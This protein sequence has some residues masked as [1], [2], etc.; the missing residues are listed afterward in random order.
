MQLVLFTSCTIDV[1]ASVLSV[2]LTS[3]PAKKAAWYTFEPDLEH[4]LGL[5]PGNGHVTLGHPGKPYRGTS[6]I[7]NR[8]S[9]NARSLFLI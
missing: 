8:K 4:W 5:A 3:P 7:R 2:S 6:I 9:Q 1:G